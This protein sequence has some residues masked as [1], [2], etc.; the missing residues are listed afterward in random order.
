MKY[1]YSVLVIMT[2]IFF[3]LLEL[4]TYSGF[5]QKHLFLPLNI[6]LY[7][8]F[9]IIIFLVIR[10]KRQP[11]KIFSELFFVLALIVLLTMLGLGSIEI[12]KYPNFVF[13]KTHIDIKNFPNLIALLASISFILLTT[14]KIGTIFSKNKNIAGTLTLL[15]AV[16]VYRNTSV[17]AGTI[18]RLAPMAVAKPSAAY[19]DKMYYL[20]SD[21][22]RFLDAVKYL[23]DE[24]ATIYLPPRSSPQAITGNPG[25]VRYFLYPRK[26]VSY[27]PGDED[28]YL[29]ASPGNELGNG[30]YKLWPEELIK[31]DY[32]YLID[33]KKESIKVIV[34]DFEPDVIKNNNWAL[35]KI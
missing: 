25:I 8:A 33:T 6:F 10:S 17:V 27:E 19:E 35:L 1:E 24:H 29:V 11:D 4:F 3:A 9:I 15:L 23:T 20:W 16:F 21:P 32:F 22:Y 34:G 12:L 13:S 14:N 31:A 30:D 18:R 5:I 26:L 2:S 28:G 7:V